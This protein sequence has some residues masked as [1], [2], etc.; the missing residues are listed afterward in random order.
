MAGSSEGGG[1]NRGAAKFPPSLAPDKGE[2]DAPVE[3]R[4]GLITTWE[5]PSLGTLDHG[6]EERGGCGDPCGWVGW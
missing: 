2:V 5:G 4:G 1:K 3:L 6:D